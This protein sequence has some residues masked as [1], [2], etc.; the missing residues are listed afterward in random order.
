MTVDV[1]LVGLGRMGSVHLE[2][3]SKLVPRLRLAAVAE[4][5]AELTA[6][7][8]VGDAVVY[9]DAVEAIRHPGIRA[10]IVATPTDSHG[11]IV[12]EALAAGVHVFCEKPLT[13]A[14]AESLELEAAARARKLVLQV[15]FW[16]RFAEPLLEARRLVRGGAIGR[17]GVLRLVQWD[18]DCPP[19]DWCD[20]ARSGGIFVDMAIHEFDEIEWLLGEPITEVAA[21]PLALVN[22]DLAAVGDYDNALVLARLAGGAQAV[23]ELSRNGRYADDLRLEILGSEGAILVETVPHSR[24]RLG[25]RNGLQTVWEREGDVFLTAIAAQLDAFA[26]LAAGTGDPSCVPGAAAS[27]RAVAIGEAARTSAAGGLAVALP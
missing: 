1:V 7:G 3:I 22:E 10:C 17:P 8:R 20:P 5:R 23:V 26:V 11:S 13:L 27:I 6:P 12:A 15:G 19:A 18:V 2:A 21:R 4:P 9:A 14:A 24:I 25:T 16:R